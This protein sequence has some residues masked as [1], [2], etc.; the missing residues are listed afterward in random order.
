MK[1]KLVEKCKDCSFFHYQIHHR[2]YCDLKIKIG[3][4]Q[5][6]DGRAIACDDERKKR[7]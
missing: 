2:S 4:S 3:V 1:T 7:K 5:L 6:R